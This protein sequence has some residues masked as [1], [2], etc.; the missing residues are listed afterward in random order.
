[1]NYSLSL[2]LFIHDFET[3][4]VLIKL[5][6]LQSWRETLI[7]LHKIIVQDALTPKHD[8]LLTEHVQA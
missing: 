1:M 3:R 8:A 7:D 6:P 4:K 5:L 2:D